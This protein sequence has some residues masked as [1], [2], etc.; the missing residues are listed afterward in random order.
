MSTEKVY[1]EDR[2]VGSFVNCSG[3]LFMVFGVTVVLDLSG[4]RFI[5]VPSFG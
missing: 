4:L 1:D 3:V 5:L 2:K